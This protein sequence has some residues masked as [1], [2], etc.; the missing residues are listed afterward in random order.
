MEKISPDTCSLEAAAQ[1]I[2]VG[3]HKFLEI[4]NT[5]PDIFKGVDTT[6]SPGRINVSLSCLDAFEALYEDACPF[7]EIVGRLG[8]SVD[9]IQKVTAG[10]GPRFLSRSFS[11]Q[12]TC[13]TSGRPIVQRRFPRKD[14]ED[15]IEYCQTRGIFKFLEP[16]V[17]V[18]LFTYATMK[19]EELVSASKAYR[20]KDAVEDGFHPQRYKSSGIA[21]GT[22]VGKLAFKV[23]GGRSAIQ[24]FFVLENDDCICLS[25][26]RPHATPWRGFTPKDG[27]TDFSKPGIECTCYKLSTG[28]TQ[29]G[30]VSF[31]S[32]SV[33]NRPHA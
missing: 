17:R 27:R 31:L 14:A 2:G 10:T 28:I 11:F 26:F 6:Q 15:F 29:S 23:W 19:K 3:S 1:K 18:T 25:A 30:G 13:P 20:Y 32:A 22:Y 33:L 24:C 5:H 21:P 12:E 16:S 9:R 4:M 7:S 8:V